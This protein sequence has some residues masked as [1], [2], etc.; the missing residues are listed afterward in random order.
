MTAIHKSKEK[1]FRSKVIHTPY[2]EVHPKSRGVQIII[3][4]A[5]GISELDNSKI[6]VKCHGMKMEVYGNKLS[7][8]V[9]EH[10][11]LEISGEVEDIKIAN[12]RN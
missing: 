7:V 3:I 4:G 8:N 9:L 12:V 1:T 10:N 5:I 11:T 6:L 2:F